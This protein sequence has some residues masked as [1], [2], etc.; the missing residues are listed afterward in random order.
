MNPSILCEENESHMDAMQKTTFHTSVKIVSFCPEKSLVV[1]APHLFQCLWF[2]SIGH[3][4]YCL[5]SLFE[6]LFDCVYDMCNLR[7][8]HFKIYLNTRFNSKIFNF[9]CTWYPKC[10]SREGPRN[11]LLR[12]S[13]L[14]FH[15]MEAIKV[16][17][18]HHVIASYQL[19]DDSFS[20]FHVLWFCRVF[21]KLHP[22]VIPKGD[23]LWSEDE[24]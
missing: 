10:W 19:A 7:K 14:A 2:G 5:K 17:L 15:C 6:L 20:K 24:A 13:R 21:C 3:P 23:C 22:F 12:L 9:L 16:S 8:H 4:V 1:L 18:A 11:F